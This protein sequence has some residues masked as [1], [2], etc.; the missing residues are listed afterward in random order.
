MPACGLW[1]ITICNLM[2]VAAFTSVPNIW[3]NKSMKK[4]DII[5]NLFARFK[6]AEKSERGRVLFPPDARSRWTCLPPSR[7]AA[8]GRPV[9]NTQPLVFEVLFLH[10]FLPSVLVDWCNFGIKWRKIYAFFLTC[11]SNVNLALFML[12]AKFTGSQNSLLRQRTKRDNASDEATDRE[13]KNTG[14]NTRAMSFVFRVAVLK[15]VRHC[16][17]LPSHLWENLRELW[18]AGCYY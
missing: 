4:I 3:H 14:E 10:V 1:K 2:T 13:N 7:W 16:L 11:W 8:C 12:K 6:Q 15:S 5:D 18:A 17:V 9:R